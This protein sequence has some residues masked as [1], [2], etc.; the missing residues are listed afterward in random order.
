M[1]TLTVESAE[2]ELHFATEEE[3][4]AWCDEDVKAEYVDG[5]VIVH[6]PA[7]TRHV[8][9][10]LFLAYLLKSF[11]AKHGLGTVLGPEVQVRLRPGLR[12]VP[13]L[14][15]VAKERT[16][17]IRETLVEGPP[18]LII[19]IVSPDST[20]RDWREKYWEYEQAGVS[21]YWVIDPQAR[22]M[23]VYCLEETGRYK[24]VP[25]EAGVY[26]SRVVSG[27]WLRSG[28]LWQEPLPNVLEV[29]GE[30]KVI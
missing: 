16:N 19:E 10:V 18:D 22:R 24:A 7:S 5:R 4:E 1:E 23:D 14:L 17:I 28:W 12:R 6:S 8:D 15:F 9:T 11:V 27:F 21:E 13:D 25:S 29:I 26:R 30:L 2:V 20:A 3:F